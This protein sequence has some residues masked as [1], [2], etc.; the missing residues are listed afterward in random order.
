MHPYPLHS[1][2]HHAKLAII[3]WVPASAG[4]PVIRCACAAGVALESL[5]RSSSPLPRTL[6]SCSGA[7]S[8]SAQEKYPSSRVQSE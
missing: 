1:S 5:E 8:H 2:V 7:L 4:L 3:N 6:C